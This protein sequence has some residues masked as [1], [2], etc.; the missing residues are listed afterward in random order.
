MLMIRLHFEFTKL[1]SPI[2]NLFCTLKNR[3]F[4][5]IVPA[6]RTILKRFRKPY[7]DDTRPYFGNG[8]NTIIIIRTIIIV[9]LA[10]P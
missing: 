6:K 8:T 1:E 4:P 3:P 9:A 5:A 2:E 7:L 10:L